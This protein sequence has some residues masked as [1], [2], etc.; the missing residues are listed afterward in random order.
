VIRLNP[1]SADA[2]SNRG[3][4][5]FSKGEYDYDLVIGDFEKALEIDP[6]NILA[7]TGIKLIAIS[8]DSQIPL[9]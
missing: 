4:A 9:P 3:I 2:Y 6:D 1:D 8:T 7:Q 5:Y